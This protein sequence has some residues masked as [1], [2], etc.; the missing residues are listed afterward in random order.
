MV[1]QMPAMAPFAGELLKF[2]AGAFRA[3]RPL[4]M[5]IDDLVERMEQ[6]AE[7]AQQ[8]KPPPPPDPKI[9]AEK[10]NL[11]ATKVKAQADICR[12]YGV[13]PRAVAQHLAGAPQQG[14]QSPEV[15]SLKAEIA[16]LKRNVGGVSQSFAERDALAKI[17]AFAA[18]APEFESVS[19]TV[20]KL[21]KSGFATDLQGAYDAAIRLNPDVAARIEAAKAAKQ[22]PAAPAAPPTPDQPPA[23]TRKAGLSISGS[24]SGSNPG[25][26]KPAGSTREA[27]DRA[28]S[29]IG[30]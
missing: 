17:E 4:Q 9:E 1:M 19:E 25:S 22:S 23:H 30:L 21:L 2:A 13:D 11:E 8:P 7:A 16:E 27:L 24:P 29:Q 14:G 6:M 28:F 15:A 10:I 12:N 5:A 26:R 20:A 3:A 18:S